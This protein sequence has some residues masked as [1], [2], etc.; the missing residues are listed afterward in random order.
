MRLPIDS[1][2]LQ[3]ATND[4]DEEDSNIDEIVTKLLQSREE[5]FRKA[6]HNIDKAQKTQKETYDRKHLQEELPAGTEVLLEN[7]AQKQ[8]KGGK[9]DPVWLGPYTISKN[10]GKGV[11]EL[12]NSDGEIM[13]KRQ[14]STG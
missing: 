3:S 11:Y 2:I 14:T 4:D 13:K 8:R 5:A 6:K 7:T 1:E 9:M 10:L 12:K